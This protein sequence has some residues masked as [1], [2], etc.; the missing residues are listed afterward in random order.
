MEN[1]ILKVNTLENGCVPFITGYFASQN[2]N[3][4]DGTWIL[5]T[6]SSI[7]PIFKNLPGQHANTGLGKAIFNLASQAD[8]PKKWLE[9]GTWN[10]NG[11]TLCALNG[12]MKRELKDNI[13]FLTYECDPFMYRI[14]KENLENHPLFTNNLSIVCGRLPGEFHFPTENEIPD[15]D[16]YRGSHYHLQYEREKALFN[17]AEEIAP[18]FSPEVI[19]LDGGLYSGL[20]DWYSIDKSSLQYILLDDVTTAKNQ[21]VYQEILSNPEWVVESENKN[22]LN[23][24]AFFKRT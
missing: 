19:I 21:K 8:G 23:G 6:E 14:A 15:N 1:N 11:T 24:W 10:G 22:E 3:N 13:S 9:V 16:K 12:F 18:F 5:F 4:E 7:T 2:H 17:T 20:F